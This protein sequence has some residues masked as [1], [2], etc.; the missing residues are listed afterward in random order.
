LCD[1]VATHDTAKNVDQNRMNLAFVRSNDF[2]RF[3]NL[4][5]RSAASNVKLK[6]PNLSLDLKAYKIGWLSSM[7]LDYVHSS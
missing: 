5:D 4:I 1:D 6:I 7:Q 2:E 3:R